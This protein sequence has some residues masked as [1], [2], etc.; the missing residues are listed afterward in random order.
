M[1]QESRGG[2]MRSEKERKQQK[3]KGH[4]FTVTAMIFTTL[5]VSS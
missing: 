3:G 2:E 4:K 5:A 1:V